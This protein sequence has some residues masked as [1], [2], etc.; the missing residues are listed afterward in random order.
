[1]RVPARALGHAPACLCRGQS[2]YNEGDR[3]EGLLSGV[4]KPAARAPDSN[5]NPFPENVSLKIAGAEKA[6]PGLMPKT[7]GCSAYRGM[8]Q[9]S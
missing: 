3:S 4:G 9:V 2:S 5:A 7:L 6:I 8:H 1:M